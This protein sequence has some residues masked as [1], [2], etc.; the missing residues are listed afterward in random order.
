MRVARM[1]G[2]RSI[3]FFEK[4][5][6]EPVDGEVLVK[7]IRLGICGT[8]IQV[9]FGKNKYMTFPVVPGH[10][11]S[12]EVVAIGPHVKDYKVGD[13]VIIRPQIVCG[14]C[15]P[16]LTGKS[17]VCENLKV[18]GVQCDGMA[19]NYFVN[20][21]KLTYK[22]P[23]GLSY[24]VAALIEPLAVGVRAAKRGL[25]NNNTDIV[26]IGA[27][28]IGN[29]TAQAAKALGAG[30]VM[31]S[32]VNEKKLKVAEQCAIDVPFNVKDKDL[33]SAVLDVFGKQGVDAIIDCAAARGVFESILSIAPKGSTIVIVGNYKEPVKVDL[34]L[35]QRNELDV[36]GD[37]MYSHN[38]F[39]DAIELM[40]SGQIKTD[41]I[42]TH[43]FD[44]EDYD[45][46]FAFIEENP[47][48]V[49]KA[50]IKFSV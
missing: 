26:V 47:E 24:D 45:K 50:L 5:I 43:Y 44:F 34:S 31:I 2:P 39:V 15:K 9:Y 36:R 19:S 48:D 13:R 37:L 33:K 7:V 14:K 25:L 18:Y 49:I 12:G 38:D 30:K 41:G 20:D 27:G 6:P 10:E 35:V 11:M 29:L 17:N 32:D 22:I 46:A 21:Q 4:P 8:D 40:Q 1:N 23:E 42:I 16:C 3:E 28:T